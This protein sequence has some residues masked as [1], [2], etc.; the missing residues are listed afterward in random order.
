MTVGVGD[1]FELVEGGHGECA[2]AGDDG[3]IGEG[4]GGQIQE[5]LAVEEV[6]EVVVRCDHA[7]C[8]CCCT[9]LRADMLVETTTSRTI[10]TSVVTAE[11]KTVVK[12][13]PSWLL[14]MHAIQRRRWKAASDPEARTMGILAGD[15][16]A[17]VVRVRRKPF[18]CPRSWKFQSGLST[19]S[20]A[21]CRRSWSQPIERLRPPISQVGLAF[22]AMV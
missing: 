18:R 7:Q 17:Q 11:P 8:T 19:K 14:T 1:G 20:S 4:L 2:G 5:G 21:P 16:R 3:V 22:P 13:C 15:S 10:V 12:V 9:L 6:R